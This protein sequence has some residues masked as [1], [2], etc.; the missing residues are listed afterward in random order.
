MGQCSNS[1]PLEAPVT[2]ARL[3]SLTLISDSCACAK[4]ELA[5]SSKTVTEFVT[6][7]KEDESFV[8][9]SSVQSIATTSAPVRKI[10]PSD[11]GEVTSVVWEGYVAA[12]RACDSKAMGEVFHPD[13]RLTFS[14]D[15]KISIVTSQEFCSMVGNRWTMDTHRS[16]SHLKNDPRIAAADSLLSVDF[17]G[18]NVAM[19]TLDIGYPPFLYHDVLVLLRLSQPISKLS[20]SSDGWWIVAKSSD[21]EPWMESE[22]RIEA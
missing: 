5:E 12:G 11:F 7:L 14:S 21:H 2:D 6:M 10:T 20:D 18:P 16:F 13:S 3:L 4:I 22:R 8:I 9:I 17:A 15:G 19:V 1:L